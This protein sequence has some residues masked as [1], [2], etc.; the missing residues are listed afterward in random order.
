MSAVFDPEGAR[1]VARDENAITAFFETHRD[2]RLR[3]VSQIRRRAETSVARDTRWSRTAKADICSAWL[4]LLVAGET[5]RFEG[6]W[7]DITTE[8]FHDLEDDPSEI[9][10]AVLLS[11]LISQGVL[12][13][14][15]RE[16]SPEAISL[17][18]LSGVGPQPAVGYGVRALVQIL[19]GN[20]NEQSER[21]IDEIC[22][23]LLPTLPVYDEMMNSLDTYFRGWIASGEITTSTRSELSLGASVL[24][25]LLW[26]ALALYQYAGGKLH[27]LC[28]FID[29]A[30]SQ[31]LVGRLI[32]THNTRTGKPASSRLISA[33][34]GPISRSEMGRLFLA[35]PTW[36][37]RWCDGVPL[38]SAYRS[39]GRPQWRSL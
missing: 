27:P 16:N 12:G 11:W 23:H 25:F 36:L 1:L 5:R 18:T 15:G 17:L 8:F 20:G 38:G 26:L 35:P 9:T 39:E 2:L 22:R 7:S 37:T 13:L 14:A 4:R 34:G 21:L 29:A 10:D 30:M 6:D 31:N 19:D 3:L 32:I 33:V 24:Y 28:R